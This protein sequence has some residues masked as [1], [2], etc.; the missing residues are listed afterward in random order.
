[1]DINK[2]SKVDGV[3]VEATEVK[4]EDLTELRAQLVDRKEECYQELERYGNAIQTYTLEIE[5]IDRL[6]K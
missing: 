6:L 4:L 3:F 2:I 1:M 5:E